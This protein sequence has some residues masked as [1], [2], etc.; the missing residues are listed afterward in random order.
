MKG[1]TQTRQAAHYQK[2]LYGDTIEWPAE[3]IETYV[4]LI[5]MIVGRDGEISEAEWTYFLG[6]AKAMGIP[7][8]VA[9]SWRSYD[10][11]KGDID[12][13]LAKYREQVGSKGAH[14]FLYDAIR[15]ARADS[16]HP[17]ERVG[18]ANAAAK[19]GISDATLKQIEHV[20]ALE[21]AVRALRISI[22]FPEP[23]KFHIRPK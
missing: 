15:V 18:I 10:H 8:E 1:M 19:L 9:E 5:L 14:S 20:I 4:H 23:T 16:Y 21:E 2:E 13:E 11:K 7:D 3:V 12:A 17:A 22:L 6:G